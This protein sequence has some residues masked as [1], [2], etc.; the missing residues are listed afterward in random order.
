MFEFM[1]VRVDALDETGE[2]DLQKVEGE[3]QSAG[4]VA[5]GTG[6]YSFD[7]RFN[8]SFKA[9]NLLLEKGASV[10]RVDQPTEGLRPGDFLVVRAQASTL[11]EIARETGVDFAAFS[12]DV[13]EG[14]HDV[15]RLR[16]GMYQRYLGGNMDEGWTR[17]LL[18][19]FAFPYTS[20][21]D[22]EI[23][24]GGLHENYD[25]IATS[26][27]PSRERRGSRVPGCRE[28]LAGLL[29]REIVVGSPTR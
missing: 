2:A 13:S 27:T 22:A 17:W 9:L 29:L 19:R 18:E 4:T 16:I 15:K 26:S 20:L 28:P 12:G 10:R 8:D 7:G 5:A 14:T 25:V 23:K 6:G 21:F 3:I 24:N 11:A 1:G